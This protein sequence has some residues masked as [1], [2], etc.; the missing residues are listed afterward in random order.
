MTRKIDWNKNHNS[1]DEQQSEFVDKYLTWPP[2]K[3][4][5]YL[6]ELASQGISTVSK[7]AER[8]IEWK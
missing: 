6:M 5:E 7:K 4:W 8:K 1:A 2:S 3:K